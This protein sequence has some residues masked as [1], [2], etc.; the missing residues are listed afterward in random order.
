MKRLYEYIES[1]HQ[2]DVKNYV[3]KMNYDED[4]ISTL[5]Q[6]LEDL[7]NLI[8]V[9]NENIIFS[10]YGDVLFVQPTK[11]QPFILKK[12]ER[13]F[14]SPLYFVEKMDL[15]QQFTLNSMTQ[16]Q[17]LG[18]YVVVDKDYDL[19]HMIL[20]IVDTL[21]NDYKSHIQNQ[22]HQVIHDLQ[23][24]FPQ[25]TISTVN[26]IGDGQIPQ[27]NEIEQMESEIIERQVH[28]NQDFEEKTKEY[29]QSILY[30]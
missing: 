10:L 26:V 12:E 3:E 14:Y 15:S 4:M 6:G 30:S 17:A 21:F 25:A 22:I 7:K 8:P 29:Y 19:T 20:V 28:I 18:A 2:T 23:S 9:Y 1:I 5:Y 13:V 11:E 16:Q 24:Q 27:D